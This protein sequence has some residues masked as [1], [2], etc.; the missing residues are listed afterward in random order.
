MAFYMCVFSVARL[1]AFESQTYSD[2]EQAGLWADGGSLHWNNGNN[3]CKLQT[4][5]RCFWIPAANKTH[6]SDIIIVIYFYDYYSR[7]SL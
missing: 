1:S 5:R 2:L 4:K 7:S 3:S 6:G